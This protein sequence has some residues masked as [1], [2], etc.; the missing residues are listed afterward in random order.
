M[1]IAQSHF[2]DDAIVVTLSHEAVEW[3]ESA[4]SQQLEIADCA[5]GKTHGRQCFG[6]CK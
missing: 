5:F 4:Y 3:T 6:M 1:P 2:R